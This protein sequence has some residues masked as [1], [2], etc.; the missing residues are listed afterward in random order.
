MLVR[1]SHKTLGRTLFISFV[2]VMFL[3][4]GCKT[5]RVETPKLPKQVTIDSIS[6]QAH[7][8][9]TLSSYIYIADSFYIKEV[10]TDTL[11]LIETK[12]VRNKVSHDTITIVKDSIVEVV[13]VDSIPYEVVVY[14]TEYVDKGYGFEDYSYFI[15]IA[16]IFFG[17]GKR[18]GDLI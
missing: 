3:L 17:L 8:D 13:R 15:L 7:T 11:R 12:Q 9:K 10:I 14:K 5:Q 1:C 4:V 2:V 18:F 16:F 6:K